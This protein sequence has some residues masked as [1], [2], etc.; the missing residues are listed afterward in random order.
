M[1]IV[2]GFIGIDVGKFTVDAYCSFSGEY[3]SNVENSKAG[4]KKLIDSITKS[5]AGFNLGLE[6]VLVAIDLTGGYE[7]LV[8]DMFWERGFK[9]HLADGKKVKYFRKSKGTSKAKTDK[10]DSRY[11]A[12]YVR[13]NLETII[14]ND[15]LYVGGEESNTLEKMQRILSRIRDLKYML[16]QE[17]NRF[18]ISYTSELD[19][20]DIEIHIKFLENNILTL[21]K[22]LVNIVKKNEILR[23]KYDILVQK[24]GIGPVTATILLA[25]LPELGKLNRSKIAALAGCAPI[26]RD[27]GTIRGYRTTRGGGRKIVKEALFIVTLSLIRDKD[28][29]LGKFYSR[30]LARG[31]KKMVAIVAV[32]R[33]LIVYLNSLLRREFYSKPIDVSTENRPLETQK[34]QPV[35]AEVSIEQPELLICK[36]DR[37]S[38]V[39]ICRK[40]KPLGSYPK[41]LA[42][43]ESKPQRAQRKHLF[44]VKN[45]PLGS[46][47]KQLA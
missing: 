39:S 17:K 6:N 21:E 24:K 10:L 20:R 33:K 46:T 47:V 36:K 31:K 29:V 28:T 23:R 15:E 37:S 3:Y 32:M 14:S 8:R 9:V 44:S 18:Q 27:S 19:P 34:E 1:S 22:K 25:F 11:L 41:Q 35:S 5:M 42:H 16:V 45:K 12:D 40:N 13:D 2:N 26:P 38:K 4:L 30:L 7:L 43:T